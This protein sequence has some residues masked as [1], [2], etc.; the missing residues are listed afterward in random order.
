MKLSIFLLSCTAFK[1]GQWHQKTGT[2]MASEICTDWYQR[3]ARMCRDQNVEICKEIYFTRWDGVNTSPNQWRVNGWWPLEIKHGT[4][5]H[6]QIRDRLAVIVFNMCI[7]FNNRLYEK[8]NHLMDI[9]INKLKSDVSATYSSNMKGTIL[10]GAQEIW[11]NTK[12]CVRRLTSF[13]TG[14]LTFKNNVNRRMET[15][16]EV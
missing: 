11:D 3:S 10:S 8:R 15:N 14:Y 1:L 12:F 16:F 2:E 9:Q 4:A 13:E 6:P 7:D 5:F